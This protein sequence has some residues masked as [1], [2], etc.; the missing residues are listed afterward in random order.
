MDPLA[1]VLLTYP[2]YV[3]GKGFK[4]GWNKDLEQDE[5]IINEPDTEEAGVDVEQAIAVATAWVKSQ[6]PKK[7]LCNIPPLSVTPGPEEVGENV[8]SVARSIRTS[9][10]E[11]MMQS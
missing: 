9:D 1:I 10:L 6:A 8:G 11:A 4:E 5:A 2:L 7:V 3:F